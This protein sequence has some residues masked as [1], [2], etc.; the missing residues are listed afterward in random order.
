MEKISRTEHNTNLRSA[1]NGEGR[2][3]IQTPRKRQRKWNHETDKANGR[4]IGSYFCKYFYFI[5]LY[6][7]LVSSF[8]PTF[9]RFNAKKSRSWSQGPP[10]VNRKRQRKLSRYMLIF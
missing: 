8:C 3:L 5:L 9:Y 1:G 10:T 2:A 7:A 6:Y 4:D